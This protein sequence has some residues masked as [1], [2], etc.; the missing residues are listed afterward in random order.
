MKGSKIYARDMRERENQYINRSIITIRFR[1]RNFR[2][3]E[4][5]S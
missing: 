3:G 2:S 1:T 4:R 5:N